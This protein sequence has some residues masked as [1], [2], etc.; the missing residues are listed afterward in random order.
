MIT[1]TVNL[2]EIIELTAQDRDT[3][4]N[5]RQLRAAGWLPATLY[6]PTVSPSINLQ[7]H[8]RDF[9]RKYH[10]DKHRRFVLS[11]VTGKP[12]VQIKQIQVHSV[13]REIQNIELMPL[14]VK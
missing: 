6:G 14:N 5:P 3:T 7:I 9:L 8:N 13:T 11:G 2:A 1:A 12:T 10:S 4:L